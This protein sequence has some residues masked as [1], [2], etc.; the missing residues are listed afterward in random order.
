MLLKINDYI[1]TARV[2]QW[3]KN[4]VVFTLP[5][6]VGSL[7]ADILIKV[8]IAFIGVS[9]ISSATYVL[10]DLKDVNID[11]LHPVKKNRP[12]ASG[13]LKKTQSIFFSVTLILL[14]LF[15]LLNLSFY[16]LIYG[17]LYLIFGYFYTIRM[18]FIPYL[19]MFTISVLFILRVLIGGTAVNIEPS[20]F[21]TL[22]IF[23]SSFCIALSKRVSIYVDKNI[24]LDSDYKQFITT[25]YNLTNLN[26][27]L[28]F[29]S[30]LS[31][32]TYSCWVLIVK[33]NGKLD[34]SQIILLV[35]IVL[36]IRIFYGI[37]YLSNSSGLEDFVISIYQKKTEMA[38]FLAMLF[39][40]FIGIYFG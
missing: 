27:L 36:L 34:F 5:V 8:T 11:K 14:G 35:S 31:I 12:I 24:P 39:S 33:N 10:N 17:I 2:W 13:R 7:E 30:V 28:K 37:Y 19:D 20:A 15:L 1:K 23:F 9:L 26:K 38:Y 29:L 4:F 40:I 21:L 6:G 16:S 3:A 25:S 22:F 32:T 18:K